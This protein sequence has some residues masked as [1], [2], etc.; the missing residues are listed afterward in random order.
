MVRPHRVDNN[1]CHLG[2]EKPWE[3]FEEVLGGRD[4]QHPCSMNM[5]I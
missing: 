1:T 2:S 3:C 4:K 5:K